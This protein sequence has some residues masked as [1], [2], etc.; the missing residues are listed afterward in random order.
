MKQGMEFI[1]EKKEKAYIPKVDDR[2]IISDPDNPECHGAVG[3]IYWLENGKASVVLDMDVD[4]W[5]GSIDCVRLEK[6]K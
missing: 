3:K 5:E 2:V 6:E 4:V 1:Q